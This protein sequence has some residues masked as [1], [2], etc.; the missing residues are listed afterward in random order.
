MP[1]GVEHSIGGELD[2]RPSS[3]GS[4]LYR[5][6][7]ALVRRRNLPLAVGSF[8]TGARCESRRVIDV[9]NALRHQRIPN[10]DCSGPAIFAWTNEM[11]LRRGI[12]TT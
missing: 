9:L 11:Y 7:I 5:I 6:M 12:V 2:D 1:S 10:P 4:A 8:R 3:S